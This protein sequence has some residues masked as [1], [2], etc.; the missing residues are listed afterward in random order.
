[1]AASASAA[2]EAYELGVAGACACACACACNT[3]S[4]QHWLWK[5]LAWRTASQ[6]ALP[7]TASTCRGQPVATLWAAPD[8]QRT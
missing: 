4:Q 3:R 5:H 1:M 7:L 2:S 8:A 6:R